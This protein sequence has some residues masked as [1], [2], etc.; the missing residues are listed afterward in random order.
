MRLAVLALLLAACSAA[1]RAPAFQPRPPGRS[2]ATPSMLVI[3]SGK[4]IDLFDRSTGARLPFSIG[5][6]LVGALGDSAVALIEWEMRTRIAAYA[7]DQHY[8]FIS[9]EIPF[10]IAENHCLLAVE[11]G[12]GEVLLGFG[13]SHTSC[14]HRE[15]VQQWVA[16]DLQTRHV[17]IVPG[18]QLAF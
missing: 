2:M 1:A 8:P 9:D 11:A 15:H 14:D 17:R 13:S 7:H 4:Y 18:R 16:V 12:R 5:G 6:E 10:D 3:Q